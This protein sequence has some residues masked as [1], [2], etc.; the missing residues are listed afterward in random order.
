MKKLQLAIDAT[1]KGKTIEH[2][3]SK[4]VGAGRANEGLRAAWQEQLRI[5]HEEC[6]F[7]YIRFHGLFADDMFVY[8]EEKEKGP[9]YHWTYIDNLFDF[10]I[11]IG[12]KPFVEVSFMPTDL[13]TGTDTVF[14]WKGNIT[15]A[16]DLKKWS[17]FVTAAVE[18]WIERY[19]IEEV[20]SWY[21]EIWNEPN[22]GGFWA[23]TKSEYFEL[24]KSSVLAIKGIDSRLRVGGPATSNFVPDER[25]DGEREDF[26][27][28]ATFT[29]DD[30]NQLNWH[31]V[32]I[33]DFLNYCTEN[34]LPV[35]FVSTH[36]Y[37]TD[38]A[39]DG[40]KVPEG[41]KPRVQGRSRHKDS[42]KEDLTWLKNVISNSIYKDAEIHLT[43]WSTSPSTRDYSHDYLPAAN[44]VVKSN[45]DNIGM[46]D[47]LSYWVFTDI[48][49][50][51][52][53]GPQAFHGGFGLMNMHGIKKPTFHA[54]RLLHRLGTEEIYRGEECII[55]KT[56]C[57]KIRGLIYNYADE[58]TDTVPISAYPNHAKA[59]SYQE[60]GCD[61]QISIAI[62]GLKAGD[63]I[64]IE[65][66]DLEHGAVTELW[67]KMDYPRNL[68]KQAEEELKQ[69]S[70]ST[71]KEKYVVPADGIIHINKTIAKWAIMSIVQ[72]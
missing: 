16:S 4:C 2:Y 58:L 8:R 48:F 6:G 27:K 44:Y 20:L 39:L 3:W 62:Q 40:Q 53:G 19:G 33:E 47:S 50:E 37:P 65:V 46:T 55:T 15:P 64:E 36:P 7:E 26:S 29:V 25:F 14:W 9:T 45:I 70:V 38:F 34:Q 52:G 17:D 51:N 61:K 28:H 56:E 71:M 35:D 59:E 31:G 67:R 41:Q 22:L 13:A 32:W 63:E 11:G 5:A 43:E 18:H 12:M 42:L 23:G 66:L 1:Q 60:M 54:Y 57:G 30:I 24:Y 49:E 21:F 69:Y 68:T 10:I 72:I